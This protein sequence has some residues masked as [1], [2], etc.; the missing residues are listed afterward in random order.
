MGIKKREDFSPQPMIEQNF[1]VMRLK[2]L[3]VFDSKILMEMGKLMG[4]I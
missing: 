2:P 4:M 1:H 3:V